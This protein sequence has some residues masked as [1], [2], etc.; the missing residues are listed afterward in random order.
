M[1]VF[2][3]T[4]FTDL[5]DPQLISLGIASEYGEEFYAEVPYPDKACTPFVREAVLPLLGQI[6]NSFFTKDQLHLEIIKWLE[7]VRRDGEE[8]F[9]CVDYQTDWDLFCDVLDCR[10]PPWCHVKNVA[11]QIN[12]LMLYHFHKTERLP[13]HHALYDARANRYAY[14]P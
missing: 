5:L 3:D 7:M 12:E 1:N 6:P 9:I 2:L 11:K 14:R 4:E 8:V 10:V 13:K